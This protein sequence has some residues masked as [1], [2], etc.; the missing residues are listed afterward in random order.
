[1]SKDIIQGVWLSGKVHIITNQVVKEQIKP[2]AAGQTV[3]AD[4][5]HLLVFAAWDTYTAERIN[6]VYDHL[7]EVRGFTNAGLDNYRQRLLNGY[8]PRD[9][10]VNFAHAARQAY[11]AFSMAIVAAAFEGVDATPME[12]FDPAALD[13]L[14]GLREN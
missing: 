5:S 4:C 1:M 2:I 8:P 7:T 6:K 9:A 12:G 11:I 14:L 3:V 13:E 10:E